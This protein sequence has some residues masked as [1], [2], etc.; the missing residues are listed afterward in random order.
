[1]STSTLDAGHDAIRYERLAPLSGAAFFVLLMA[2]AIS[3]GAVPDG[4]GSGA[5]VLS[6]YG[7]HAG[8]AKLSNLL[9]TLGC[10]FLVLFASRLRGL[11]RDAG[12]EALATAAFGGAIVLAVGGAARAGIGWAL[13]SDHAAIE[14]GAA[15]A[16]NVLFASHYPAITGIAV[17]ML[18][19]GIA[20]LRTH[21]LPAALGWT[22]LAIGVLAV[23]PP[24]LAPLIACGLWLTV[25][26][27]VMTRRVD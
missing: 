22:A 12:A 1:M 5:S 25:A 26:A 14:P 11:L 23:A 4:D 21:A 24:T 13:A 8:A 18:A 2:S 10:V 6:F 19:A 7:E 27:I 20:L 16:L 3:G 17:L 9:A 15:Q